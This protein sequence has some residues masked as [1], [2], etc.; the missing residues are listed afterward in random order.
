VAIAGRGASLAITGGTE[1]LA[2]AV[3]GGTPSVADGGQKFVVADAAEL[4]A[5][6]RGGDTLGVAIDGQT[7]LVVA[8]GAEPLS[9]NGGG[10]TSESGGASDVWHL[11]LSSNQKLTDKKPKANSAAFFIRIL[12][13]ASIWNHWSRDPAGHKMSTTHMAIKVDGNRE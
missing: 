12:E 10:G 11:A 6:A 13:T 2:V 1:R 4:L 9:V 7:L 8:G 5:V 3:G